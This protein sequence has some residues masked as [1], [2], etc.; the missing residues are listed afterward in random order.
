DHAVLFESE[1]FVGRRIERHSDDVR[2]SLGLPDD[3]PLDPTIYDDDGPF[4]KARVTFDL[5]TADLGDEV[6]RLRVRGGTDL[7]RDGLRV[8]GG[9][10]QGSLHR[11]LRTNLNR[12]GP[13][14]GAL[15]RGGLVRFQKVRQAEGAPRMAWDGTGLLHHEPGRLDRLGLHRLRIDA[16]VA[17]EGVRH[18]EDLAAVRWIGEEIGRA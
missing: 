14:V 18:H 12:E 5:A 2:V 7:A 15:Q 9:R 11:P 8:L 6:P 17:D 16:V 13:R 3:V 1:D 4:A 10:H